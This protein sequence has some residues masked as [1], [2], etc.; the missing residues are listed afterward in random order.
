[1]PQYAADTNVSVEKT[2]NEIERTLVRYGATAF[3]Y[4]WNGDRQV[5]QFAAHERQI[6]FELPLPTRNER[7][8]THTPTGKARHPQD[9]A[10]HWEQGCRQHWRAL[11]LIIKAKLEAIEAGVSTFEDEWL[12]WTVMPDGLTVGQQAL[13]VVARAYETGEVAPL[14]ALGSG[15]G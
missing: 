15:E 9:A 14:L 7:R 6:R 8:F 13:P 5:I 2:R 1:M 4:G 11:L 10:K 12:S 3:A